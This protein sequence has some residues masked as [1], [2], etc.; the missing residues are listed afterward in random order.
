MLLEIK[1]LWVYYGKAEVL[2]GISMEI[3]E[4]S[5]VTLLGANGAG[6]TTTLRTISG[7]KRPASGEI[8]FQGERIDRV[9]PNEIIRRGIAHVPEGRQLFY[10][11]TVLENLEMGAYLI[12]SRHE[13]NKNMDYLYEHFPAVKNRIKHN[14]ANLSGGEQQ[15]VAVCR[16]LMSKPRVLLMDEPSIGLSPIMV[17]EVANIIRQI[18]QTGVTIVLVEQNARMALRLSDTAYV[19]EVGSITM[20]GAAKVVAQD[21]NIIKAYLGG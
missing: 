14:A 16:A 5:I 12:K 21:Q 18:N 9:P 13:I 11:M 19:L 4:G 6:K 2:K 1:D 15:M 8:W 10:S 3:E 20:K 7:L 17:N